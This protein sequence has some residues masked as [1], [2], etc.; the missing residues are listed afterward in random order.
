MTDALITLEV[1]V[2]GEDGE[3][4]P[5]TRQ[6]MEMGRPCIHDGKT[7]LENVGRVDFRYDTDCVATALS[8][9][10]AGKEKEWDRIPLDNPRAG[11]A[12]T[13]AL[14]GHIKLAVADKDVDKETYDYFLER[15]DMRTL[16]AMGV[17]E[18]TKPKGWSG[19]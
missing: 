10:V 18:T 15:D 13:F 12:G 19:Y 5:G 17:F 4:I 7:W 2:I 16:I 6:R 3:P 9:R 1:E 8:L 14:P 11:Y